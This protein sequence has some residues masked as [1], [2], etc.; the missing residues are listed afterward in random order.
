MVVPSEQ[1]TGLITEFEIV[2]GPLLTFFECR[3]LLGCRARNITVLTTTQS[4]YALPG[5]LWSGLAPIVVIRQCNTIT[6]ILHLGL[7]PPV[8]QDARTGQHCVSIP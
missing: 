7:R 2:V 3:Y 4:C 6:I 5:F 8:F 1:R